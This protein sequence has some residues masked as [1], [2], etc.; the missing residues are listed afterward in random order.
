[1]LHRKLFTGQITKA[2]TADELRESRMGD[3]ATEA[4][5]S[6]RLLPVSEQPAFPCVVDPEQ[7]RTLY[8]PG[9]DP[10][11]LREAPFSN[12]YARRE[13]K[14]VLLVPWEM[15]PINSRRSDHDPIYVFS[16]GRC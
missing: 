5:R 4:L 2:N 9:L 14:S 3:F 16:P 8:V 10:Q 6:V 7:A 12:V 15:G 11:K 1:M 13:A